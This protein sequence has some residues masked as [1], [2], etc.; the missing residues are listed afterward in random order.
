MPLPYSP[1]QPERAEIEATGGLAVLQ[2][3]ADWCG[4]CQAAEDPVNEVLASFP[5]VRQIKVEDGPGRRLG[6]S[7]RVKLW[8][9][10]IFLRHG[11]EIARLV[12]PTA[13]DP[14]R[15]AMTQLTADHGGT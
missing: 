5:D 12:R 13:V 15:E 11:Q 14:V 4:H 3:G 8:P 2:F 10:L 6:R 7:Y 1:H 9:T